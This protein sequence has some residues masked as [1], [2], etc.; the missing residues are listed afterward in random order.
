[1]NLSGATSLCYWI[2]ALL[3]DSCTILNRQRNYLFQV[4]SM[5]DV[6]TPCVNSV[7]RNHQ[8]G[9]YAVGKLL[10]R[11]SVGQKKPDTE[12]GVQWDS[13][14]ICDIIMAEVLFQVGLKL[15]G[16]HQLLVYANDVNLLGD[17]IETINKNS[18]T[19]TDANNEIGLEVYTE[20]I[21]CCLIAKMHGK[22]MT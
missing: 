22:I 4:F 14:M 2:G 15:N 16:T 20:S 10:V 19:L 9:L 12:E 5:Q 1:M 6:S 17:I 3:A 18:Q 21:Y 8:Y 11:N 7:I 13:K